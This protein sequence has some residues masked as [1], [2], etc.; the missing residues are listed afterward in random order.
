M[1]KARWAGAV[2]SMVALLTSARAKAQD[3][4]SFGGAHRVVISAERLFGYTHGTASS[5]AGGVGS[6][7]TQNSWSL[8]GG[9]LSAPSLYATPHVA[10][11][12]FVTN[13][14]TLGAS[15]SYF[16]LTESV[17]AS[18]PATVFTAGSP[19]I[20]Q[21]SFAP[22]LGVSAAL[23]RR[24]ALWP[25][26]GFTYVHL[27]DDELGSSGTVDLYALTVEAPVIFVLAPHF[28]VS[29]A[30]TLD[31]GLG[32]SSSNAPDRDGGVFAGSPN[33]VTS[34]KATDLGVLCG[35]GGF[36]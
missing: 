29:L 24:I 3:E 2:A 25:R 4:V 12:V 22:R 15:A 14:L 36:L 34:A 23:G 33:T 5:N 17:A 11:D 31:L 18:G 26:V 16:R 35:L 6:T 9:G 13:H 27:F 10:V 19:T 30:P 7:T 21:L 8:L 28:F 20:S 32:G 1:A